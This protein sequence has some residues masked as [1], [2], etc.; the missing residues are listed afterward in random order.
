MRISERSKRM[1]KKKT[2]RQR[3]NSMIVSGLRDTISAHGPITR[4]LIGSAAKRILGTLLAKEK[5]NE[6]LRCDAK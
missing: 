2:K 3:L 6:G 5:K 1:G 4:L